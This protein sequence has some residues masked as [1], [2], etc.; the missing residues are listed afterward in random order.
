MKKT[1]LIL[2]AALALASCKDDFSIDSITEQPKLVVYCMP[3]PGD[4]THIQVSAS[5]PVSAQP[6]SASPRYIDNATIVYSVN[7]KPQQAERLGNGTYRVAAHQ[8]IGDDINLE[9]SAE[10][11]A[12]VSASTVIPDT[13]PIERVSAKEITLF[14]SEYGY[15]RK[16][17]QVQATFHDDGATTDYYA[18]AVYS[19]TLSGYYHFWND[20]GEDD[21]YT[22]DLKGDYED[23]KRRYDH[24]EII[25]GDEIWDKPELNLK[26]EPAL[27]PLT[28][29]DEDF[30]FEQEFYRNFYIFDDKTF[31]GTTYTL[32]L[33][34]NNPYRDNGISRYKVVL[35]RLAPEYYRFILAINTHNNSWFARTGFSDI[36]PSAG[37]IAGGI[38]L[39]GGYSAS[40]RWQEAPPIP[41]Q[42]GE[43]Y[44][45]QVK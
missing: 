7:G 9:V 38:G 16:Y 39:L 41:P 25:K 32:H 44:P 11:F 2:L 33:N 8:K 37:N 13:V 14:D 18:V 31:N 12:S 21:Y 35:Y 22:I 40:S 4:T 29:V 10:G 34:A 24:Y 17:D 36:R 15:A 20:N 23:L 45:I 42:K 26:D 19:Y 3:T 27:H 5:I 28:D 1:L 6:I 30:G 43:G